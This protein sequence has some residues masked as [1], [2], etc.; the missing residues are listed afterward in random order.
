MPDFARTPR[1]KVIV[2]RELPDTT[3]ARLETLFDAVL[4]RDDMPVDRSVLSAAMADADVLVP[5]V[6]DSID[7]DLI[8]S[9]GPR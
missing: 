2:T 8:A 6:T 9:A 4:N 1:P 7:A 5:T 3:M